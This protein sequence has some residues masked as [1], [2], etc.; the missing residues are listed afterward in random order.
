MQW[1]DSFIHYLKQNLLQFLNVPKYTDNRSHYHFKDYSESE[2]SN[3][4]VH[5]DNIF[6]YNQGQNPSSGN[7]GIACIVLA[8][9]NNSEK[10]LPTKTVPFEEIF[11]TREFEATV[12][13]N[14]LTPNGMIFFLFIHFQM[15]PLDAKPDKSI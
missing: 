14:I 7:R 3:C 12:T 15:R 13:S 8:L 1:L 9:V 5:E 11:Q 10:P 4:L 2:D 6:I